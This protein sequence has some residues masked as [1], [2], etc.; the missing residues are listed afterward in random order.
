MATPPDP[1]TPCLR[2]RPPY[3][4]SC[5]HIFLNEM[6][7]LTIRLHKMTSTDVEIWFKRFKE[8][9]PICPYGSHLAVQSRILLKQSS[10][11]EN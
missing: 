3:I 11:C 2:E 7:T 9:I 4:F 5:K 6:I 1:A 8:A 10:F